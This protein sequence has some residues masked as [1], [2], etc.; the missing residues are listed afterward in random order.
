MKG[1][2]RK[3]L[4][5]ASFGAALTFY[6]CNKDFTQ[7]IEDVRND[8]TTALEEQNSTLTAAINQA[9]E[10]AQK[11]ADEAAKAAKDYADQVAAAAKAE[12]IEEAEK[13]ADAALE[14]A[15]TY[16]DQVAK[17]EAA[18]VK[19]ELLEQIKTDLENTLADAKKYTDE[20]FDALKLE[21]DKLASRI[22]G[23]DETIN[24]LKEDYDAKINELIKAD[25]A[26]KG[27]LDL[28]ET[29]QEEMTTWKSEVTKTLGDLAAKDEELA[30]KINDEVA[31]LD[32]LIDD[33]EETCEELRGLI[34]ENTK[35]IE[36]LQKEVEDNYTELNGKIDDLRQEIAD[37]AAELYKYIDDELA[38]LENKIQGIFDVL[39]Q[40]ISDRLTSISLIP[41]VYVGGVETFG[42]RGVAF[43][44]IQVDP[45]SEVITVPLAEQTTVI[46]WYAADVVRYHLSP[47]N[48]TVDGIKDVNYLIENA[49]FVKSAAENSLIKVDN[50]SLKVNTRN[51][52]EVPVY[53]MAS[54]SDDS[55]VFPAESFA[56]QEPVTKATV[57]WPTAA[58]KVG[59]ADDLLLNDEKEANVISEYSAYCDLLSAIHITPADDPCKLSCN[60]FYTSYAEASKPEAKANFYINF[61][62]SIDLL[63]EVLAH[64]TGYMNEVVTLEN[65]KAMGLDFRFAIPT[66]PQPVGDNGTDQQ[67][68]IKMNEDGHSFIS[69]VPGE[70]LNNEAAI[71]RTPLV[72]VELY[73]VASDKIVDAQWIK[74]EWVKDAFPSQDLGV[75][76]PDFNDYLDCTEDYT[77]SL[78]WAQVNQYIIA[79]IKDYDGNLVGMS[80]AD[81][82][83]FYGEATYKVTSDKIDAKYLSIGAALDS[84]PNADPKT[85]V[86]TVGVNYQGIAGIID[87]IV[88][89]GKAT[90]TVKVEIIPSEEAKPYAGTLSFSIVINWTVPAEY[91]PV[92]HYNLT[93]NWIV[94][95]EKEG[96]VA[97]VNPV[98]YDD[99]SN[100][101]P[102][103]RVRY[104]Y[105]M[106]K[107]FNTD[108]ERN[109]A[110]LTNLDDA[111]ATDYDFSC[112]TWDMQFAKTDSYE[113]MTN[114]FYP[115][116]ATL[117]GK[118]FSKNGEKGGY[119]F[120]KRGKS[121]EAA[122][123][124]YTPDRANW[125]SA[126]K[127][128]NRVDESW[129]RIADPNVYNSGKDLESAQDLL[130]EITV[131]VDERVKIPV[132]IMVNFGPNF[133]NVY[134]VKT[135]EMT[136]IVPVT[137]DPVKVDGSF[138]DYNKDEQIVTLPIKNYF[139]STL[140]PVKDF[141]GRVISTDQFDYYGISKQLSWSL[142]AN[143]L[144]TNI[145]KNSDGNIVVDA[146]LDANNTADRASMTLLENTPIDY[147]Y[148]LNSTAD[149]FE[150]HISNADGAPL[151][152]PV[153]IWVK[154]SYRHAFE[155]Y[156]YYVPF[157]YDPNQLNQ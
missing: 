61:D 110:F 146:S 133:S 149:K 131:P 108:A 59:I 155:T 8:L 139:G 45:Q 41:E 9:K 96:F 148:T 64:V 49:V 151:V 18:K 30:K 111:E 21:V 122:W 105:D 145:V 84:D 137:L 58:L 51:E 81:Y 129:F 82:L 80:H 130:N 73:E 37:K 79:A 25:E 67:K 3:V 29:F 99:N 153:T 142:D 60:R 40:V 6:G 121:P 132:K 31:R 134:T 136:A 85:A 63:P 115:G 87:E 26:M 66:A 56:S 52:L 11:Y 75:I 62:E 23:I 7:D 2:L 43:T 86:Y 5:I 126:V 77:F 119:Q 35:L 135:F 113:G 36:E 127:S 57:T 70:Y 20:K 15:K 128:Q 156:E 55:N 17:S 93:H 74:I 1:F 42:V 16:A 152:D 65:I 102:S 98:G 101:H 138:I 78:N 89:N 117:S 12:A 106:L 92:A 13:L 38:K 144:Y 125:Y 147:K 76:P 4:L 33:L 104:N 107:L 46:P 32:S 22:D 71:G 150:L 39:E 157:T 116:Y 24:T 95:D 100:L 68:F 118:E 154:V 27:R 124:E 91:L 103:A 123:F 10:D 50:A 114:T 44:A 28:L 90:R 97:Q 141:E 69:I 14:S 120:F 72:R 88:E 19:Q 34:E 47:S 143:Q 112:R 48:V 54:Y 140:S 94:K 109:N 83:H 53:R